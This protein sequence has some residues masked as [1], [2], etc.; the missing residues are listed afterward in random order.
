M[1][2]ENV[3]SNKIAALEESN[4]LAGLEEVK[5]EA[6][7][8]LDGE[9]V[10]LAE[11][12]IARLH[13]K[14]EEMTKPIEITEEQ[15]SQ[16]ENLGGSEK[17]LEEIVAPL[18]EK[19]AEKEVEIERVAVEAEQNIDNEGKL[20][21]L[22]EKITEKYEEL[23][24]I[25]KKKFEHQEEIKQLLETKGYTKEKTDTRDN[26]EAISS[27]IG[28]ELFSDKQ[29]A[30]HLLKKLLEVSAGEPERYREYVQELINKF[31]DKKLEYADRGN[32][33]INTN[34]WNLIT[35]YG[36]KLGNP[37]IASLTK[38][39]NDYIQ[40]YQALQKKI[41]EDSD[42]L[43]TQERHRAYNKLNNPDLKELEIK[44]T[45]GELKNEARELGYTDIL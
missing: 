5:N 39:E 17:D 23:K 9:T 18:D 12:A 20:M 30:T 7:M 24:D 43:E 41:E 25:D 36:E 45:L 4:D 21:A 11:Q 13:A 28:K 33:I 6:E 38:Q 14:V 1:S 8:G 40:K 26:I 22:K 19:I 37:V 15:K 32:Q 31:D 27:Q 34:V 3:M 42:L 29:Q 2:P 35:K 10:G 16:A 44:H